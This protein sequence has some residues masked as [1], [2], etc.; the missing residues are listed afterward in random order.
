MTGVLFV[1]LTHLLHFPQ[2]VEWPDG[3]LPPGAP[4][5]IGIVGDDPFGRTID[6]MTALRRT[7]DHPFVVRRLQWNE[8]LTKCHL[9]F[10]SSSETEHI[11]AILAATHG[12]SILTIACV[13][14]FATR[15]GMIELFPVQ[16]G[17]DFDVN[18]GAAALAHLRISSKLLQLAHAIRG[19]AEGQ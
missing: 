16:D 11:D 3:V 5:V 15:G 4:I 1:L 7:K 18:A 17:I 13:D 14:R 10:I 2:F 6:E 9:I 8:D 19:T 12:S